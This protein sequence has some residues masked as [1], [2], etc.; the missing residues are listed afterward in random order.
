MEI[1]FRHS[2]FGRVMMALDNDIRKNRRKK[3]PA[4]KPA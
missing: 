1:G 2:C 4:E 3:K